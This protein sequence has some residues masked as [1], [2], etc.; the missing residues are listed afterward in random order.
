MVSIRWPFPLTKTTH[1]SSSLGT[2]KIRLQSHRSII[3]ISL[4]LSTNI[5]LGLKWLIAA[6]ISGLDRTNYSCKM[7]IL[8]AGSRVF[9]YLKAF[10]ISFSVFKGFFS[11]A[12][13]SFCQLVIS[14]TCHFANFLKILDWTLIGIQPS[15]YPTPR[16]HDIQYDDIRQYDSA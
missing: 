4:A 6:L 2:F 7:F 10:L 1:L 16:R 5:I 9:S 12:A 15:S 13:A 8:L 3:N 11:V 14:S